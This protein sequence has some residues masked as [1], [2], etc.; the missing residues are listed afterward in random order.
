MGLSVGE[1]WE[2]GAME[3]ILKSIFALQ[4]YGNI[5]YSPAASLPSQQ[6]PVFQPMQRLKLPREDGT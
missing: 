3:K 5:I 1:G 4:K 6:Y 2:E